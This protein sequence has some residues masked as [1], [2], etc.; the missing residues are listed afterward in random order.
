[1][2]LTVGPA[3]IGL[4]LAFLIPC[5]LLGHLALGGTLGPFSRFVG[6]NTLGLAVNVALAVVGVPKTAHLLKPAHSKLTRR[7]GEQA[8]G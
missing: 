4:S 8:S 3:F 5:S 7:V 6:A 2:G 1:M